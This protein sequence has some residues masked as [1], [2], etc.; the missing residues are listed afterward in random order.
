[1]SSWQDVDASDLPSGLQHLLLALSDASSFHQLQSDP[2]AA[3]S[4]SAARATVSDMAHVQ[5]V[6]DAEV[7][8]LALAAD[9]S[10]LWAVLP[11]CLPILQQHV[12]MVPA[13]VGQAG[14]ILAKMEGSAVSFVCY[15]M[16]REAWRGSQMNVVDQ[17]G[18]TSSSSTNSTR[19]D[20]NVSSSMLARQTTNEAVEF[21]LSRLRVF[22][23][24]IVAVLHPTVFLVMQRALSFIP[25][26]PHTL[27]SSALSPSLPPTLGYS[28][29]ANTAA[30]TG[31]KSSLV[32]EPGLMVS[33]EASR[34][35]L[36]RARLVVRS[37]TE[38]LARMDASR[39]GYRWLGR[40]QLN[41]R[42]ERVGAVDVQVF[43]S[44]GRD[45]NAQEQFACGLQGLL[46]EQAAGILSSGFGDLAGRVVRALAAEQRSASGSPGMGW[47]W[48]ATEDTNSASP[49]AFWGGGKAGMDSHNEGGVG[50][51]VDS[52]LQ[53]VMQRLSQW[54]ACLLL[55][56]D[57]LGCQLEGSV[58]VQCA[59]SAMW[60]RAVAAA[61]SQAMA[62]EVREPKVRGSQSS[63][64][65]A[66]ASVTPGEDRKGFVS[67]GSAPSPAL[68]K[69]VAA[70]G[71]MTSPHPP[72]FL[73][74]AVSIP[75][76]LSDPSSSLFLRPLT[77][78]FDAHGTCTLSLHTLRQLSGEFPG[79]FVVAEAVASLLALRVQHLVRQVGRVL[80]QLQQRCGDALQLLVDC[81]LG[82]GLGL[83]PLPADDP[84]QL[85]ELL[86]SGDALSCVHGLQSSSA[87]KGTGP[88]I[89]EDISE[90]TSA[91]VGSIIRA[92]TAI[93][94]AAA[95]ILA[96]SGDILAA[97]A[98][99]SA[100]VELLA[101]PLA[102][103]GQHLLLL[104][105]L[106]TFVLPCATGA[107]CSR[108]ERVHLPAFVTSNDGAVSAVCVLVLVTLS[109]LPRFALDSHLAC[110]TA[111]PISRAFS[112]GGT[113]AAKTQPKRQIAG[114][115]TVTLG[116]LALLQLLT[117]NG[118]KLFVMLLRSSADLEESIALPVT[119]VKGGGK[120]GGE[121]GK[122]D[123]AGVGEW[124]W[125][126]NQV[127]HVFDQI[128]L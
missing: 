85:G 120:A 11:A 90:G 79:G 44:K 58:G 84:Q 18:G 97:G 110:L 14:N 21:Y 51:M 74:H 111:R 78:W 118:Y 17:T 43:T 81:I 56:G 65:G 112:H 32:D 40:Q 8:E 113:Q 4:L 116:Q 39:E 104:H 22:Q 15:T 121:K 29:T 23:Q 95:E 41:Q 64:T 114:T 27:S 31:G 52:G 20:S 37:F 103:V 77:A 128:V 13:A 124:L 80:L 33:S 66:T 2:R 28:S 45:S 126:M 109:L 86:S 9:V 38:G 46:N 53:E 75:L 88:K 55:F 108:V 47:L 24:S 10:Y 107:D 69:K 62:I 83:S 1:M 19:L 30:L 72:T 127:R 61:V 119:S 98:S 96:S 25:P 89:P 63:S 34:V 71:P 67:Q 122:D 35:F 117:P 16:G 26:S 125:E 99:A 36:L 100:V 12:Q 94:T 93:D 60:Q 106:R 87:K 42:G 59:A 92:I 101:A 49:W 105:A 68:Q 102:A 6:Q 91:A 7:A 5:S 48:G 70:G 50:V 76:L 3:Q 123:C 82:Q 73:H 57:V 54:H 115:S